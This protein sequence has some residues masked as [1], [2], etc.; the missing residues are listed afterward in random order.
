MQQLIFNKMSMNLK[1]MIKKDDKAG[2]LF[3]FLTNKLSPKS[4]KRDD[5]L[6]A[7]TES[8]NYN[9]RDV[10]NKEDSILSIIKGSEDMN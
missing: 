8:V 4:K 3:N 5:K 6:C 10:N 1:G 9:S 7:F 2:N